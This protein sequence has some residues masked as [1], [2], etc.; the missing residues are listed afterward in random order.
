MHVVN[1]GV[2][3]EV[4][5]VEVV[6]GR[7][8]GIIVVEEELVILVASDEIVRVTVLKISLKLGASDVVLMS[9]ESVVA[10]DLAVVRVQ[11]A[12]SSLAAVTT[13]SDNPAGIFEMLVEVEE[14]LSTA[15]MDIVPFGSDKVSLVDKSVGVVGL[16]LLGGVTV[17]TV[18]MEGVVIV[19]LDVT[20]GLGVMGSG[21]DDGGEVGLV[22]A[23]CKGAGSSVVIIGL[24][25][26]M[27]A[28]LSGSVTF[29]GAVASALRLTESMHI[30]V[31]VGII[32]LKG[33]T[34]DGSGAVS[35]I[36]ATLRAGAAPT[37]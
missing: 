22:S 30:S 15:E 27:E 2:V 4:Q 18:V 29:V 26:G 36:V 20:R 6:V 19:E 31:S 8:Q 3:A 37:A 35:E 21:E 9:S 14:T 17:S 34:V 5:M 16:S 32:A 33:K 1:A 10:S 23:F 7:P 25:S 13:F 11:D 12:K 28:G 24:A